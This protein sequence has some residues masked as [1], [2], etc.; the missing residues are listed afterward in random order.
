M[1]YFTGDIV[2]HGIWETSFPGNVHSITRTFRGLKEVFP[3]IPIYPCIANHEPHPTN[4]FAPSH[5]V[6]EHLSTNRLYNLLAD[7]WD[8]LPEQART[9]VRR[10]GYYTIKVRDGFRVVGLNNNDGYTFNWWLMYDS[11]YASNQL[12]WLH[13][14][15]L[16]AERD[17]EKV[18]ILAH[19]PSGSADCFVTWSREYN[20]IVNRFYKTISGQFNGHSH[21]DEL[22]IFYATE[23]PT[24][25]INIAWNGG[26][27]TP[28]SHV[29]ANYRLY[30]VEPQSYVRN[31]Y[32]IL[33]RFYKNL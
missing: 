2:D 22:E 26:S 31:T 9:T 33:L 23:N 28:Y 4:Q 25:A 21:R 6:Q 27:A 29:N 32:R 8:W 15:L 19:I 18:H 14:T 20:R 24:K 12:Q 10:F 7:T 1:I 30:N 11:S 16:Q 17:N 5:I 3:D 13:D